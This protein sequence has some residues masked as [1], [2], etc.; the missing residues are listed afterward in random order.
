LRRTVRAFLTFVS[1]SPSAD[2][3]RPVRIDRSILSHDFVTN[4][5]S[6]EVSSVAFRAQPLDLHPVPLMDMGFAIHCP[7]ARHCLPRIQ[8]LSIGSRLCSTLL[9]DPASRRRPCASL[10]LHVHHVVKRTCTSK[11]LNMLGTQ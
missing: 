9:S 10:S 2:F 4:G 5:R 1:T 7:L 8:F 3:S 6:P 11:L